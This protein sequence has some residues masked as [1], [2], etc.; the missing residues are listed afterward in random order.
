MISSVQRGFPPDAHSSVQIAGAAQRE[1]DRVEACGKLLRD[2]VAAAAALCN[3]VSGTDD[4]SCSSVFP[5]AV[6]DAC[7]DM[8]GN[9]GP[10]GEQ[11]LLRLR[12]LML[13]SQR[14]ARN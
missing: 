4:I 13:V 6:Y 1:V 9:Q 10:V 8:A 7:E 2:I 12:C 5:A 3:S 14:C 11:A